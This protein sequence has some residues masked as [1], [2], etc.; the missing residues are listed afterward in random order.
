MLLRASLCRQIVEPGNKSQFATHM[1]EGR[2]RT[3]LIDA[4]RRPTPEQT[5][6]AEDL[7]DLIKAYL[8]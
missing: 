4:K 8:K 3:H 5:Q 7:L 1:L 6:A 2:I